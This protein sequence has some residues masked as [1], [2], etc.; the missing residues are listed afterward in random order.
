MQIAGGFV[1]SGVLLSAGT[2][3]KVETP[4]LYPKKMV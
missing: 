1:V 2:Y 3:N 4:F